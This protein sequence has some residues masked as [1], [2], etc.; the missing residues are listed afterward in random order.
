M[1]ISEQDAAM[2]SGAS[3][4]LQKCGSMPQNHPL[5]GKR[6]FAHHSH[7]PWLK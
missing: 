7:P 1:G 3:N 4:P 5:G 6:V 2:G